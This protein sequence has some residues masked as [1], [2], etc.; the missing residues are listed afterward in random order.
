MGYELNNLMKMYG[1]STPSRAG[2]TGTV[3]PGTPP[4]DTASAEDKAKFDESVRRYQLDRKAYEQY[5]T[6]YANRIAGANIYN[7]PQFQTAATQPAVTGQ[8]DREVLRAPSYGAISQFSNLT[9]QQQADLYLQQRAIGYTDADIRKATA[10]QIGTPSEEMMAGIY[11]TAYPQFTS[12]IESQYGSQFN[13]SGY[14]TGANQIDYPGFNYYINQLSTGAV[15]PDTLESAIRGGAAPAPTSPLTPVDTTTPVTPVTPYFPT[16]YMTPEDYGATPG[17]NAAR[18]GYINRYSHGGQVR[19]HY[20]SGGRSEVLGD[21]GSSIDEFYQN[22]NALRGGSLEDFVRTY[23]AAPRGEAPAPTGGSQTAEPP[24]R[25]PAPRSPLEDMLNRYMGVT[26]EASRELASA[27]Q[28]SQAESEAFYNLIRQQAERGE[29][30]TSRAEM[31]FR[32]ASAFGAPTR[33]GQMGETLANVGQQMSEYTRGRRTEEGERRNLLL[34]AQEAR[35]GAA[36]EDL[37]TT[38]ALAAQEAAERRALVAKLLEIS[39]RDPSERERRIEDIMRTNGVDRTTA[40]NIVNGIVVIRN[41]PVTG[42]QEQVN[43]LTNEVAPLRRAAAPAAPAAGGTTAEPAAPGAAPS[44]TERQPSAQPPRTLWQM[45][46]QVTGVVPAVQEAVQGVTGQAGVN[47][48]P[49]GLVTARQTFN[50][51]QG[52]L[53]RAL[54]NNA[55][56]PVGEMERIRQEIAITPSAMTDPRSLRERMQ[57]VDTYLRNRLQNEE[58]AGTDPSLPVAQRQEAR[59]AANDIRNFLAVLGVPREGEGTTEGRTP[60]SRQRSEQG[61][62]PAAPAGVPENVWRAMTPEERALWQN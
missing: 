50:N 22:P 18:G 57:S 15:T 12:A 32:L 13:R 60:R 51:A 31:Y 38:R 20:Q 62:I 46:P 35:M 53:I 16:E 3:M 14:G 2:Y 30:P 45:A 39:A 7:Q 54:S 44:G 4:A 41:N 59:R 26:G 10:G 5:A 17:M 11:K 55:R 1:V 8:P 58:R 27:R 36:R 40:S 29:S 42:E 43:V 48:A 23:T 21:P 37:A 28:R 47:V 49:E 61:N 34:R 56:F 24:P 52:E 6:D 33:T 25:P 19:T 9:P